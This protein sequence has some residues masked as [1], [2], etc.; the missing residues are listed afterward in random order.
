M[1]VEKSTRKHVSYVFSREV[2][3]KDLLQ[4]GIISQTEFERYDQLLYDR[5]HLDEGLVV[6]RPI[7][8]A[9]IP[10]VELLRNHPP[11]L[12]TFLLPRKPA[13]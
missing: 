4:Q 1:D 9:P 6:P 12:N 8:S 13:K 2:I 3:L 11:P 7:I 5:Y 10:N